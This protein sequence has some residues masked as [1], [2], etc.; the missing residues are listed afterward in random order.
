MVNQN[1][2]QKIN[3]LAILF[4]SVPSLVDS[5]GMLVCSRSSLHLFTHLTDLNNFHWQK[6]SCHFVNK[7]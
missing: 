2:L 1:I 3:L 6:A 4:H 5:A 7:D